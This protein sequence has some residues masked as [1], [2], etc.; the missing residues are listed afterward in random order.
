MKPPLRI[1]PTEVDAVLHARDMRRNSTDAERKLWSHLR[2]RQLRDCK[3]RRQCLI[4]PFIV[5]FCCHEH[6]LIIELDGSQHFDD[7][8]YDQERSRALALKGYRVLR[9]WNN[10]V[11]V[12]I[13]GVL[14]EVMT[15]LEER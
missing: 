9:F 13:E 2:D 12:G 7:Q 3:F 11:L 4:A 6:K 10:E 14:A 5:D 8:N 15:A 1:H